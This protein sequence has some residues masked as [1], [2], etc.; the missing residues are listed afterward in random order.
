MKK[1]IYADNAATTQLDK[2]AYDAML[3]YLFEEYGNSSQP[4]NFSKSTKRA[5]KD[6]RN[7]IA[8]CINA[9]DNEI[10]FTSGGTESDNWAIKGLALRDLKPKRI[11]ISSIEHHAIINAANSL[12]RLGHE[13]IE[14]PVDKKGLIDYDKYIALFDKPVDLVSIMLGNNEIGT[15]QDI[16][17]LAQY[18]HQKGALFHTDAVQCV[19]HIDIDVKKL[20][21]DMLSASAH[22]FNGPKGMGFLYI[23]SGTNIGVFHDGGAQEFGYRAGTEDTASI[24]AMSIALKNNVID[25]VSNINHC[26]TLE[27]TIIT[28]L[29][30]ASIDFI[31]N[32][33][34]DGLP[35]LISLSFAGFEG[36]MLMHRMDLMGICISTGS[37]CDS[38]NTQ[39]SHVISAINVDPAYAIGTIRISLSKNNTIEDARN[40]VDAIVKIVS[41]I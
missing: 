41:L 9:E 29:K 19:G 39:L 4:Y 6:A 25:I 11:L 13:V 5:I 8:K 31:R 12:K 15:I 32:G 16:P 17:R 35:G 21:V 23:K 22:K 33:T 36:E 30:E 26:R 14:I 40:I 2:K 20:D 7:L 27:N 37:A 28:R 1:Y 18:A 38:V 34:D 10:Y 24:V 3:P